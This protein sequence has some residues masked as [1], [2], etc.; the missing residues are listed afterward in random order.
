M[1]CRVTESVLS[2]QNDSNNGKRRKYSKKGICLTVAIV[3]A[4]ILASF[5]VYF[6]P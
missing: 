6:I 3:A 2:S 5:V 4:I 1:K